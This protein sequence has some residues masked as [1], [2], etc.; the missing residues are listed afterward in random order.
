MHTITVPTYQPA[1]LTGQLR[2]LDGQTLFVA[3]TSTHNDGSLWVMDWETGE[4]RR[5]E[6]STLAV[7]SF[8]DVPSH[9]EVCRRMTTWAQAGNS[10]AMWWLANHYEDRNHPRSVWF[11]VA[12]LRR[13]PAAYRW[14][15]RSIR[16]DAY[17]PNYFRHEPVCLEFLESIPEITEGRIGKNWAQAVESAV[18]AE[19]APMSSAVPSR[20]N[21]TQ[22]LT[23]FA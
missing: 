23:K 19:H 5:V 12:A 3:G 17:A 18:D 21:S 7:A 20:H 4:S 11:F 14:L 22:K 15:L 2:N 13:N 9:E 6:S 10:D 8:D 16:S 1:E